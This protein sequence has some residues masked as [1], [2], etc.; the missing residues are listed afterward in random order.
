M[1]IHPYNVIHENKKQY[2]SAGTAGSQDVPDP[3]SHE[4]G[5]RV[6]LCS[7]RWRRRDVCRD[8]A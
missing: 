1:T 3:R 7:M 5:K 4:T 8:V 6:E 2:D